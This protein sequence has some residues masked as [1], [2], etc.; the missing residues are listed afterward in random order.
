MVQE[1]AF[2][3][4][5]QKEGHPQINVQALATLGHIASSVGL[6]VLEQALSGL[7]KLARGESD[8]VRL[9]QANSSG[10]GSGNVQICVAERNPGGA[11]GMAMGAFYFRSDDKRRLTL[12]GG[13]GAHEVKFWSAA[14]RMVLDSTIYAQVRDAVRRRLGTPDD[15]IARLDVSLPPADG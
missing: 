4:H 5:E 2:A 14:H 12:F 10:D 13:W 9:L 11:V 3:K 7:E 6:A 15:Y 1:G 8:A